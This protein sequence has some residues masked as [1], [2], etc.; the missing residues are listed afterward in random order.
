[1]I[2]SYLRSYFSLFSFFFLF[3]S[4]VIGRQHANLV[5]VAALRNF[6]SSQAF[7]TGT[8]RNRSSHWYAYL[9]F[10]KHYNI[11][12]LPITEQ[13]VCDYAVFLSCSLTSYNSV[14][15]YLSSLRHFQLMNDFPVDWEDSYNLSLTLRGLK[16]ILGDS[17]ERKEPI[18]PEMLASAFRAMDFNDNENVAYWALFVLGFFSLL[19]RSNL[20]PLCIDYEQATNRMQFLRRGDVTFIQEGVLLSVKCSK[21]IQFRERLLYVVVPAI[22]GSVLCPVLAL[23]KLLSIACMPSSVPLF[24]IPVANGFKVITA[25]RFTAKIKDTVALLGANPSRFSPHSFRRGGATFAFSSGVPGEAIKLQCDWKSD[26]YL[27]YLTPSPVQQ[28][29]S[30]SPAVKCF[31]SITKQYSS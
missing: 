29:R 25:S 11:R 13:I 18:T 15:N 4:L 24:S 17:S 10:C 9:L 3:C 22:P 20:V 2:F 8:Y 1:M 6:I 28:L 7:A 26:A 27:V 14:R 31:Q 23:Q 21:T 19:R 30:L 12:P 5:H 16:R